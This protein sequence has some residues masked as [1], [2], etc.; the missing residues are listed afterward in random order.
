MVAM[1]D[2][3][4]MF[5]DIPQRIEYAGSIIRDNMLGK[6]HNSPLLTYESIPSK[7]KY[8]RIPK[9]KKLNCHIGQRKLLM[10]EIYFYSKY[11]DEG[12]STS[13]PIII[14]AGSASGE[15]TPAILKMFPNI[16]LLLIDPNYHC[17][18]HPYVCV[19]FNPSA[20]SSR[21]HSEFR[22]YAA[23]TSRMRANTPPHSRIAHLSDG[24]NRL[25][26]TKF[27]YGGESPINILDYKSN[28]DAIEHANAE[29]ASNSSN[30]IADIVA[31]DERVFVIQDYANIALAQTL[32]QSI[33]IAQYSNVYFVA[34]IRTNFFSPYPVDADLLAN[35]A[36][37]IAFLKIMKP[38]YSMLKFHPPYFAPDDDSVEKLSTSMNLNTTSIN[39]DLD[40]VAQ[41]YH[42]N[43]IED[44]RAGVF[45]YFTNDEII[46]Q[47]WGPVGTSEARFI[48]SREHIDDDPVEYDPAVWENKYYYL[49][50]DRVYSY[51][52]VYYDKIR[53]YTANKYDACG[54]CAVEIAI[55][56]IYAGVSPELL[57]EKLEDPEFA[58]QLFRLCDEINDATFYDITYNKKCPTH[59]SLR[60]VPTNAHLYHGTPHDYTRWKIHANH[61]H[62]E[63]FGK[64]N[65]RYYG[66]AAFT[67]SENNP[68]SKRVIG[69]HLRDS[70]TTPH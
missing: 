70:Y 38:K 37:Q 64:K 28:I 45:R 56:G 44:Y 46:N 65:S 3:S 12:E 20:V 13:P 53:E 33:E 17:I 43:L 11:V 24:A 22:K 62:C 21:N 41:Q 1:A 30:L 35:Y 29:F 68:I 8:T 27:M 32:T 16:K 63:K 59:G 52:G 54:D 47:P 19:R 42:I 58:A 55:L 18:A 5:D 15:H 40:F 26:E 67:I 36:L 10:S 23:Y 57:P 69:A 60:K 25:R 2:T 14:Y 66:D 61:T 48:I 6:I 4:S 34:D 7:F 51:Y 31:S 39:H 9:L 50:Y 49:R